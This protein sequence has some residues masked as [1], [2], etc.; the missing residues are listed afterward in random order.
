M[1][2]SAPV[3]IDTDVHNAIGDLLPYLPRVWKDQWKRSKVG[4]GGL[5]SSPINVSR[6]D[7]VPSRGGPPGSDPEFLLSDHMDRYGIDY[8][9]LT[10]SNILSISLHPDPDYANA[11]V[12]AC[13]DCMIDTWLKVSPRFKG[14][15]FINASDPTAAAEEIR[16]VGTHPQI[17]QVIMT[18]AAN[19]PYGQRFYHPIYAAAEELGL[20]VA[21]HSGC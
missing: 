12:T 9:I 13:N 1:D 3:L 7:A 16:R 15:I 19:M 11:I 2:D 21:V 5:Y 17:V 10:G 18:S 20:P 8:A 4:I 6:S 14:S